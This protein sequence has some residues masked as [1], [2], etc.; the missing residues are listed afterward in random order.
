MDR[1]KICYILEIFSFLSSHRYVSAFIWPQ[2]ES[3]CPYNSPS[4]TSGEF[5]LIVAYLLERFTLL[6]Y[7]NQ[8]THTEMASKRHELQALVWCQMKLPHLPIMS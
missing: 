8:H 3:S 1:F 7:Y 6:L 4:A 2:T 5:N